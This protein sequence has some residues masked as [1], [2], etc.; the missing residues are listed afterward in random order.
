[1]KKKFL[2][3]LYI[4]NLG[5]D[6]N[7]PILRYLDE[8]VPYLPHIAE[9]TANLFTDFALSTLDPQILFNPQTCLTPIGQR[10]TVECGMYITYLHAT[11]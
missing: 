6:P 11:K 5:L 4:G 3:H 10:L 9:N 2:I 7:D 1:M 8:I